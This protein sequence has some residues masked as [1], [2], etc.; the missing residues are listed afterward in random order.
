MTA[1]N[2]STEV[3][4]RD[5]LLVFVMQHESKPQAAASFIE[6]VPV[7][8]GECLRECLRQKQNH[9]ATTKYTLLTFVP[10]F[11]LEQLKKLSNVLF[12]VIASLSVSFEY[13][14]PICSYFWGNALLATNADSTACSSFNKS[15]RIKHFAL[16][17]C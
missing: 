16:T 13:F 12:L 1:K 5:T 3:A 14:L 6:V 2:G 15:M 8:N 7:L 10:I 4:A 11:V 17:V 9:I